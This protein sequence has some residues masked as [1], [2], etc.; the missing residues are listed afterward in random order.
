M[1]K[2]AVHFSARNLEYDNF[3]NSSLNGISFQWNQPHG[4]G[5]LIQTVS[6]TVDG[7]GDQEKFNVGTHLQ[8]SLMYTAT[9]VGH[10]VLSF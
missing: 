1:Y 5:L 3:L 10:S 4:R 9:N 6:K 7:L 2:W 8:S